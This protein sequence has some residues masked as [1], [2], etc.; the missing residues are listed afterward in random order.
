MGNKLCMF[1]IRKK[2]IPRKEERKRMMMI[3]PILSYNTSKFKIITG[4]VQCKLRK[5]I[6]TGHYWVMSRN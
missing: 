4:K 2:E 6:N 3:E 5:K 1:L